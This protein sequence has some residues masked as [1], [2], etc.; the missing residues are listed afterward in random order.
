MIRCLLVDDDIELREEVARYLSRFGLSVEGVGDGAAMRRMLAESQFDIVLLDLML[1]GE[2]GLQ[3]CRWLR[4]HSALP[5][6]M[7][8]A[9][10]D[11][12]SRVIGLEM[13]AD[14]YITKPFEPREII[15]RINAVLRRTGSQQAPSAGNDGVRRFAGW[16]F[17]TMRHRMVSPNGVLV[18]LSSAEYR[19]LAAFLSHP[20]QVL[21]RDRLLDLTRAPGTDVSDRSI[22][23][24]VSR[25]RKKLDSDGRGDIIRTLR[26]EGYLF[27]A[28]VT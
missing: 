3:L 6:I 20:Q 14:D 1:P 9:K 11:P 5:V 25:L 2:D 4:E 15:A 10:G 13:G 16:E 12:M 18:A 19:L 8:T 24:A 28:D 27:D 17:D 26:S 21:S 22:D 23:L 7:L